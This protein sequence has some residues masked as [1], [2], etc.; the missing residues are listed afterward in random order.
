MMSNTNVLFSLDFH[1]Y[2][3]LRD[4]PDPLQTPPF[5]RIVSDWLMDKSS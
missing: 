2:Y 3:A 4:D 1:I 5:A